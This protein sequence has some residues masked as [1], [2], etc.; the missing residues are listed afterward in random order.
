MEEM[1]KA[2]EKWIKEMNCFLDFIYYYLCLKA[3]SCNLE[4]KLFIFVFLKVSCVFFS[5]G[6]RKQ[7]I[8]FRRAWGRGSR[9]KGK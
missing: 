2:Q 8:I 6:K 1:L 4:S 9:R 3:F 5:I 7:K